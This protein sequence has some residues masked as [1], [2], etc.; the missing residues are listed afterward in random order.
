MVRK[1]K[2][3]GAPVTAAAVA[4]GYSRPSYYEAAAALERS[5]LEGLVPARPGPRGPHKLTEADPRLGRGA[6]GR[7]PGAAPGAAAGP[8]SRS[9]SACACTPARSRKRWPAAGST[10]PK[11]ADLP[12]R[13]MRKEDDPSLSLLPSPGH[14]AA[15]PGTSLDAGQDTCPRR[16]AGR[17]LRASTPCRPARARRG[18]PARA[19][20]ADPRW[21]HRL[22]AC[23]G[24]PDPRPS[25][26]AP[27][28]QPPSTHPARP[29]ICRSRW[30]PSSS[31]PWRP[32]RSPEPHHQPAPVTRL[33]IPEGDTDAPRYRGVEGDRRPPLQ[34]GSFVCPPVQP[35]AGPPQHRVRDPPVRPARQGDRAGLGRQTRSP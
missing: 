12:A 13:E 23:P 21:R 27:A 15:E 35:Q 17:P 26:A 30:P 28:C 24:R 31:A 2:A 1:V 14:A 19:R 11:A 4:F 25:T 22:A 18:V 32:S 29:P 16:R 20:R 5:G 3:D 9:P 34:N 8:A 10:A 7:R 6:T 33:P